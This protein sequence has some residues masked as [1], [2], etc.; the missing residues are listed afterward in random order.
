VAA[1]QFIAFVNARYG[2]E[3]AREL[4]PDY[5]IGWLTSCLMDRKLLSRQEPRIL[6]RRYLEAHEP[7]GNMDKKRI[8]ERFEE[9][10]YGGR[11]YPSIPPFREPAPAAPPSPR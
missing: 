7:A 2:G 9:F 6:Y 1:N 5:L 4:T 11:L 3:S 8:T 10:G